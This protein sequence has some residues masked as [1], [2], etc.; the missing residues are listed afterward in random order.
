MASSRTFAAASISESFPPPRWGF[1][2]SS[3]AGAG[4]AAGAAAG[5]RFGSTAVGF[6]SAAAGLGSTA[7]APDLASMRVVM[8]CR[9]VVSEPTL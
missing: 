2:V 3:A 5:L 9:P 8:N 7:A 1:S 6:G 4:A